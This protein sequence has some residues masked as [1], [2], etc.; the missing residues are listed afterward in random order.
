MLNKE[1]IL[2]YIIFSPTGSID[3]R[4]KIVEVI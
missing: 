3:K 1:I 2:K 4:Q